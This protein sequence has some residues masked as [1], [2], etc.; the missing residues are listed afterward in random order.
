MTRVL[1]LD[2]ETSMSQSYKF[3]LEKMDCKVDVAKD[4]FDALDCFIHR[5]YDLVIT[6]F[7]LDNIDGLQMLEHFQQIDS[8]IPV[9]FSSFLA[10]ED[11]I[12]EILSSGAFDFIPK[13]ADVDHLLRAFTKALNDRPHSISDNQLPNSDT[14]H[15]QRS[16]RYPKVQD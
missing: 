1:V 16:Q 5:I 10:D 8:K 15:V 12:E 3:I 14:C 13:P 7:N 9:I 2:E 11:V 6:D 4:S